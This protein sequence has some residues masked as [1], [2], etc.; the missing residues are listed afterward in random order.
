MVKDVVWAGVAP[1]SDII[2]S[3]K[4]GLD[5]RKPLEGETGFMAANNTVSPN[6]FAALEIPL[7][8]GRTFTEQE[9]RSKA[10]VIIINETLAWIPTGNN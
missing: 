8:F 7:L 3:G 6:Y 2:N 4:Y 10:A 5:G 1:L 9:I